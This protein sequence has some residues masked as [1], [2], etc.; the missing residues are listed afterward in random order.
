MKK[1]TSIL[2]LALACG[3]GCNRSA[4][5]PAP[6]RVEELPGALETAFARAQ[7]DVKALANQIVVAVQARNYPK[8]FASLQT[9][10]RSPGL[11][12]EQ[13]T[14]LARATLTINALLQDARAEGDPQAARTLNTY[15]S[16]K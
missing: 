10:S 9:L 11:T 8:A 7:P 13:L 2:L 15:R 3:V 16:Q 6:L 5:P 1:L 14:I 4:A 12:D